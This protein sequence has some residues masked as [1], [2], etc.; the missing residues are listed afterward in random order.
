MGHWKFNSVG[1]YRGIVD[2]LKQGREEED[3]QKGITGSVVIGKRER[4][5]TDKQEVRDCE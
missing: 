5:S 3:Q 4:D 1:E 2:G